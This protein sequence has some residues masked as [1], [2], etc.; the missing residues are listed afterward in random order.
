MIRWGERTGFVLE[1]GDA[2]EFERQ[3]RD[4]GVHRLV[5]EDFG[6]WVLFHAGGSSAAAAALEDDPGWWWMGLG[7]VR[8]D[9]R[10][11]SRYLARLGQTA[12]GD[13][14]FDQAVE[15]SRKAVGAEACNA[16]ARRV[17]ID[18]LGKLGLEAEAATESRTLVDRCEPRVRTSA[19]FQGTLQLLGYTLDRERVA[20]GQDVRIRYFWKVKRDPGDGRLIGVFVHLVQRQDRKR[21]FHGEHR[22]LEKEA[23]DDGGHPL[24]EGDLV[25]R[26]AWIRV[27]GDATPGAYRMLLSVHDLQTGQR[28]SAVVGETA[29][30]RDR[31][32]LGVLHVEEAGTP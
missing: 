7:A 20:P 5:R 27:P 13:G 30:R 32:P 31:V 28:W 6:R 4:E 10:G 2:D 25:I 3:I 18:A 14:R 26:E 22:L 12:Y 19:E 16:D 29:A 1:E 17:L 15:L 8:T 21:R 9:P 24:R 11:K 23:A